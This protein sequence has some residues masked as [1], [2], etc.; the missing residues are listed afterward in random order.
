MEAIL[1]ARQY[2][3]KQ[4]QFRGGQHFAASG[5]LADMHAISP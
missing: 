3:K 2:F 4:I 5:S 1:A